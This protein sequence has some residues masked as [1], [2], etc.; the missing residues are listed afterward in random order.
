MKGTDGNAG[1]RPEG[2]PDRDW[3]ALRATAAHPFLFLCSSFLSLSHFPC[4]LLPLPFLPETPWAEAA[5][6]KAEEVG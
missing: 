1:P 3:V 6:L 5:V 4:C 2:M